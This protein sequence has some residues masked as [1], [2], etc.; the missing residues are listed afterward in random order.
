MLRRYTDFNELHA[1]MCKA[2]DTAQLPSLP[3]KLLL[4]D[5][6]SIAERHLELDGYLRKLLAAEA[7]CRHGR[8]LDFLGVEKQGVRYGMRRYEYD[9]AQSEGNRYIRDDDL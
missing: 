2:V 6:E 5:D 8:V 3:P 1:Q 4:N 9:S 7:T